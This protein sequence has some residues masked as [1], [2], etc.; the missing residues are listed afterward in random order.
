VPSSL[1][2]GARYI[3]FGLC[4]AAIAIMPSISQSTV[5]CSLGGADTKTGSAVTASLYTLCSSFHFI[6]NPGDFGYHFI[7]Q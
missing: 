1:G 4:I 2:D 5:P 3:N 6:D 7:A